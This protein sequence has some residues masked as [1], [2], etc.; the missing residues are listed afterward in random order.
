MVWIEVLIKIKLK[1]VSL[2]QSWQFELSYDTFYDPNHKRT[3][4]HPIV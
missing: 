4:L 2:K 3:I 1:Y